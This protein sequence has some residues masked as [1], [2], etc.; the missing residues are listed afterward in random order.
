M[1][2]SAD[3]PAAAFANFVDR[4]RGIT[5]DDAIAWLRG[6]EY[7]LSEGAAILQLMDAWASGT[8]RSRT[9]RWGGFETWDYVETSEDGAVDRYSGE[10]V[11]LAPCRRDKAPKREL[12][13]Q[14]EPN[15]ALL[16]GHFIYDLRMNAD[17]LRWQIEQQLGKP[18]VPAPQRRDQGSTAAS[19][20]ADKGGRPPI[21]RDAVTEWFDELPDDRRALG[22]PKLADIYCA[23]KPQRPGSYDR[24]RKIIKDLKLKSV[25]TLAE[26]IR[27]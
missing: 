7:G 16:E 6:D 1:A 27:P 24:V 11:D 4:D 26:N 12:P 9:R 23:E 21:V 3:R 10:R 17:D 15:E 20:Q 14:E 22:A 8:V 25:L 18:A 19:E 5:Q 13:A 2:R